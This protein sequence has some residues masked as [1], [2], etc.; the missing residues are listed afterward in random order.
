MKARYVLLFVLTMLVAGASLY[1][2]GRMYVDNRTLQ[3]KVRSVELDVKQQEREIR[4]LTALLEALQDDPKTVER[5]ARE[6]LRMSRENET[7]YTFSEPNP[8][9]RD[10]T[11]GTPAAGG[12]GDRR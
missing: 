9:P 1:F 12:D 8:K 4:D 5:I 2:L 11:Y 7:I 10:E 3:E 6:H